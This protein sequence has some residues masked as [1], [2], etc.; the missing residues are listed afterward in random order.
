MSR[1]RPGAQSDLGAGQE[2]VDEPLRQFRKVRLQD[3]L[4]DTLVADPFPFSAPADAFSFRRS[5]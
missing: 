1:L 3:A 5:R 2:P 4:L